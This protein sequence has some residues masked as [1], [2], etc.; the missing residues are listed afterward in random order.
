MA[1]HRAPLRVRCAAQPSGVKAAKPQQRPG[2]R[3]IGRGAL[4]L[5]GRGESAQSAG[6]SA[7]LLL[8][9]EGD[10]RAPVLPDATQALFPPSTNTAL[11]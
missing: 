1:L 2:A 4:L 3:R 10:A 7:A 6:L 8:H 5:P 9:G 11:L